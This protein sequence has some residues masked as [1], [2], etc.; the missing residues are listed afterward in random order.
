M[1]TL[2]KS[3]LPFLKKTYLTQ[4][5]RVARRT[6]AREI[7]EV[8]GSAGA[9]VE[10]GTREALVHNLLAELARRVLGTEASEARAVAAA[11]GH[12]LAAIVARGVAACGKGG[13]HVAVVGELGVH[14][15]GVHDEHRDLGALDWGPDLAGTEKEALTFAEAF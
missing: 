8:L 4:V 1:T 7:L 6:L 10:A 12:T 2:V 13:A 15:V 3:T 5:A 9:A 14:L 11:E